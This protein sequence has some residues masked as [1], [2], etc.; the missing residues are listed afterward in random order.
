MKC[1][2]RSLRRTISFLKCSMP[3]YLKRKVFN[4]RNLFK[5]KVY[6][7][8]KNLSFLILFWFWIW[9]LTEIVR[10]EKLSFCVGCYSLESTHMLTFCA[11]LKSFKKCQS[12]FLF[13]KTL[14]LLVLFQRL[15]TTKRKTYFY[16]ACTVVQQLYYM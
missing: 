14:L 12:R 4:Q 6:L 10:S 13:Y 15:C 1:M 7:T 2:K 16:Y 9:T 3:L 8:K 11:S 5:I